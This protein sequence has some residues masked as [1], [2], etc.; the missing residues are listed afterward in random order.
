MT[1]RIVGRRVLVFTGCQGMSSD[2]VI[3]TARSSNSAMRITYCQR[4]HVH[5]ASSGDDETL[6]STEGLSMVR[7]ERFLKVEYHHRSSW[8]TLS[9]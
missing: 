7:K 6:K 3:A 5:G 1:R 2:K 8:S 9:Y 4:F